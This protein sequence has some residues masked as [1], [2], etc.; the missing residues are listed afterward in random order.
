MAHKKVTGDDPI[1]KWL[2]GGEK[3]KPHSSTEGRM[4]AAS[5]KLDKI[6]KKLKGPERPKGG[7]TD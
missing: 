2:A 4:A 7:W 5:R 1:I 3:A 6:H